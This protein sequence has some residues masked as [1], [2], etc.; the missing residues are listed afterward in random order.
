MAN[1]GCWIILPR[2]VGIALVVLA[3]GLDRYDVMAVDLPD[4]YSYLPGDSAGLRD[5]FAD[6]PQAAAPWAIWF[7]WDGVLAKPEIEREL[8]EMA[9]AG[10]GGAEIRCV[11]FHGW[12]GPKLS[13][14]DQASLAQI[15]HRKVKYLFR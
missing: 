9:E 11:T 12:S 1:R 13:H 5:G 2:A 10:F 7:W 4:V 6:P 14:M 8:E 3:A 15:G